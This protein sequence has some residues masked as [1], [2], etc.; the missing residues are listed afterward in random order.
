MATVLLSPG[1]RLNEA[2][3][4]AREWCVERGVDEPDC[5]VANYLFPDCKVLSGSEE[6]LQYI[7]TNLKKFNIRKMKKIPTSGAFHTRLMSSAVEPFAKELKKIKIEQPVINVFMNATAKR[8]ASPT[9]ILNK[10]PQQ[11]V[12]PVKWEQ[13]MHTLYDR[14]RENNY[15]RTFV[16]GPGNALMTILEKCNAQAMNKAFKIE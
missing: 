8:Y 14:N 3:V 10:L 7:E 4:K 15:P 9:H 5:V 2:M 12:R 6:A 1:H 16:C 13:I 11:I